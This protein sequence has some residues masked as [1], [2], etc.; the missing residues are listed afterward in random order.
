MMKN[1][2]RSFYA[3]IR[4][5]LA[6]AGIGMFLASCQSTSN[7]VDEPP[8]T[9]YAPPV[10]QPLKFGKAMKI[11]WDTIKA[12]P[13]HPLVR[14]FDLDKLPATSY[15]TAGFKPFKYPVEEAK[16]DTNAMPEKDLDID[17]LP[18][19]PLKFTMERLPPP[20]LIHV[21]LPHLKDLNLSLFELG[22]AQG[23]EDG[24]I[25]CLFTDRDGF[26]WI[27]NRTGL[28]RYD[29][30][31]LLF[32]MPVADHLVISMVQDASGRMWLSMPGPNAGLEVLDPGAGTLMK[33]YKSLE[34]GN[35]NVWRI[36]QD[37][38][39][40]IWFI[41]GSAINIIDSKKET[42]QWLD[43]A[44]GFADSAAN[45]TVADKNNRIW[46]ASNNG[47]KMIDLNK[48]KIRFLNKA[49]GLRSDTVTSLLFD[50]DGR[51]W[52][53]LY[54]GALN[55]LDPQ[56]GVIQTIKEAQHSKTW[57]HSLL[58]DKLGKVWVGTG[59]AG[60]NGLEI[61]DP[62]KRTAMNLNEDEGLNGNDVS[63][64]KQDSQGQVWIGTLD[65]GLNMISNNS[66]VIE[67]IGKARV[68]FLAEDKRGLE[69]DMTFS[70]GIDIID[71]KNK[72]V[73]HLG[74]KQGL[75]ND[76]TGLVSD[77]DGKMFILSFS[78]LDIVDPI[79]KTM[80]RIGKAQ[81]FDGRANQGLTADRSGRIW[82]PEPGGIAVFDPKN[83]T[84]KHIGKAEYL[85]NNSVDIIQTDAKGQIW[86]GTNSGAIKVIDPATYNIQN[87]NTNDSVFKNAGVVTSFLP[88]KE[89]NMWIGTNKGIFIADIQNKTLTIFSVPQ[90]L[91]NKW[92]ATL[93]QR[94]NKIYASTRGE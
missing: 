25:T 65:G 59:R 40:R 83:N 91:I 16:M 44:H 55:V 88:D 42:V 93:L 26:L 8:S 92:V 32:Y 33:T 7:D 72:T 2:R 49:S 9:A 76:T 50:R 47:L 51:L 58:Q 12:T 61:I 39:Q 29:G 48:K 77:I 43:K 37:K 79:E 45:A 46:I 3:L 54:G 6:I 53:G 94:G 38:Q 81:G 21:G 13:V 82:I 84:I 63:R 24:Y 71:R 19:R 62:E 5:M 86:V 73:R 90:G 68:N 85:D 17:K 30:E 52:L 87:L 10:V 64:L 69:W 28:Y 36:L 89:G 57:I 4:M 1:L 75:A 15:D 80:S 66:A 60:A 74:V 23:L 56:K 70:N 14:P 35:N 20:K 78:G 41:A 34:P 31:N 22:E 27:A 11:N 18:S 67:R